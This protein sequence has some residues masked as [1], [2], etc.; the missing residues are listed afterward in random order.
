MRHGYELSQ[1]YLMVLLHD[2]YEHRFVDCREDLPNG[3]VRNAWLAMQH[4][5]EF[6]VNT[7]QGV[8]VSE[9]CMPFDPCVQSAGTSTDYASRLNVRTQAQSACILEQSQQ[10]V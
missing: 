10:G 5:F 2:L 1:D 4:A 6:D 8:D 7:R 9:T 3:Q